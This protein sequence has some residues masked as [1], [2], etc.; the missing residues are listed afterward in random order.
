MEQGRLRA[1]MPMVM[2]VV[3]VLVFGIGVAGLVRADRS[4]KAEV[5]LAEIARAV[6][7][8]V[9]AVPFSGVTDGCPTAQYVHCGR[10]EDGDFDTVLQQMQASLSV[11][12][13]EEPK[14]SCDEL[15][16]RQAGRLRSCTIRIDRSGHVV[17]ILVDAVPKL[18]KGK[19]SLVGAQIRVTTG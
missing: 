1:V 3:A 16:S 12:A 18:V 15:P 8:P 17:M 10:L 13:D 2:T 4:R 14:T 6:E 5:S 19:V 9:G 11:V 7:L